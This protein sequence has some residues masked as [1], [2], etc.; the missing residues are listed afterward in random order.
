[1]DRS[2]DVVVVGGGIAGSALATVLARRGLAVVVLER[3]TAYRDKVRGEVLSCWGVAEALRLDLEKPL[4]DAGGHYVNRMVPYDEVTAPEHAAA[5]AVPLDRLLPDVPGALDVGH[6]AACEALLQAAAAAGAQVVRGVGELDV[7][8]GAAPSVRYRHGNS[9][10]TLRCAL[11]VGADGRTSAVRRAIGV[12]LQHST[13]RTLGG[14]MLVDGLDAWPAD[15]CAL[16]TEGDL[17]Y[18]M[19]PRAGGRVRLYLLH[20]VL[21]RGRFAGP[22]RASAF[23][24]AYRRLTCI[25]GADE[26]FAA[27]RPAGPCAFYPMNDTWTDQPYA[28]GVVLVGDAAGWNDPIIGQGLS[29]ALRDARLVTDILDAAPRRL[30]ADF[31]P[32]AA[33][34]RERMRR[35]RV[36]ARVVTDLAATFGPAAA[37]RRRAYNAIFRQDPVLGGP[38]QVTQLGPDNVPA[39]AFERANVERILALS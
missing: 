3:Q 32:Y 8:P 31:A 17:H 39:A 11:V 10:H 24:S 1:M 25:P 33:E 6:P 29:I 22:D 7:E 23:L 38:R 19:F 28:P 2:V 27:A 15:R 9:E 18:L 20:D 37:A 13:P 35:L 14:G 34:R 4:L 12:E 30:A 26:I 16:G 36:A 5:G 21:Q